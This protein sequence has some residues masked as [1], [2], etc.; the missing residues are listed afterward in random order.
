MIEQ[1]IAPA[2]EDDIEDL[3]LLLLDATAAGASVG[4][5]DSTTLE[6]AKEWWRQSIASAGIVL[7]ARDDE[8]I[9]GTV[10][11]YRHRCRTSVIA[12]TSPSSSC[13]A[14]RGVKAS[15]RN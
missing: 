1:L 13:I 3:A 2:S 9:A 5:L 14:A 6:F 11:L 4:F 15:A 7:V 12:P 8:G 10:Q